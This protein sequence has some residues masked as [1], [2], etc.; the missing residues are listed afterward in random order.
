MNGKRVTKNISLTKKKGDFI[1]GNFRDFFFVLIKKYSRELTEE[2]IALK[3]HAMYSIS[4]AYGS[5]FSV[6]TT[7]I[8]I[9]KSSQEKF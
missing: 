6:K 7:S 8:A 2:D 4:E 9:C 5:F 1:F 3:I